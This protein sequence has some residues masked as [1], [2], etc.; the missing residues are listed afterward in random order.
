MFLLLIVFSVTDAGAAVADCGFLRPVLH[1]W[2]AAAIARRPN[3]SDSAIN[4]IHLLQKARIRLFLAVMQIEEHGG[5]K[6]MA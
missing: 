4:T 6:R 3:D 2:T 5:L 1:S